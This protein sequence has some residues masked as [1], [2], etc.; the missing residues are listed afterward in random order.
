MLNFINTG[1]GWLW[2]S[3]VKIGKKWTWQATSSVPTYLPEWH[4]NYGPSRR[5]ET[6]S[7]L[8][9]GSTGNDV[10][11]KWYIWSVRCHKMCS[12]ICERGKHYA[13]ADIL[14]CGILFGSFI[15]GILFTN[16]NMEYSKHL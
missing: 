11:V 9:R 10:N 4:R 16:Q 13:T 6:C 8:W 1:T 7:R 12:Y 14:A 5:G 15:A 2:T 3:L